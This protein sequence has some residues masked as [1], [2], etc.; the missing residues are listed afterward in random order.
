MA[1][2]L[3]NLCAIFIYRGV[4]FC[5]NL[6]RIP[7]QAVYFISNTVGRQTTIDR[8]ESVT[9]WFKSVMRQPGAVMVSASQ[10]ECSIIH[11]NY[12][13]EQFTITI[14]DHRKTMAAESRPAF[15]ASHTTTGVDTE[16]LHVV[17]LCNNLRL[18]C[19]WQH[20][21][22]EN[23][24]KTDCCLLGYRAVQHPGCVPTLRRNI[25]P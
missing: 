16:G 7:L 14:I 24:T 9:A 21:T 18:L 19:S 4:C 3:K 13:S 25:Q 15:S 22:Q 5:C 8:W 12:D 17:N 1:V 10:S 6:P 20:R 11:S 23:T 2:K